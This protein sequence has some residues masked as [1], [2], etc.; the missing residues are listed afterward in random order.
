MQSD[1]N[2]HRRKS[3]AIIRKLINPNQMTAPQVLQL[4]IIDVL[5]VVPA[6]LL[7]L[8]K[9]QTPQKAARSHLFSTRT[10]QKNS[11]ISH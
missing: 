8:P 5:E 10:E 4:K 2:V 9:N 7:R 1:G 11:L 6:E 3:R